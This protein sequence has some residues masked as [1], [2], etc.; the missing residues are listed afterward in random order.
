MNTFFKTLWIALVAVVA[1]GTTSCGD[2]EGI[3]KKEEEASFNVQLSAHTEFGSILT[4]QNNQAMYFFSSDMGTGSNCTG[5]CADKWPPVLAEVSDLNLSE[6]LNIDY[7]GTIVRD[8][9]SKQ[10]TYKGWPLYYFSPEGND[11]LETEGEVTGDAAGNSFFV[12]KPDYTVMIG[13][14]VLEDEEE[15]QTYLVNSWG[16]TIYDFTNDTEGVSNCT[17]G[18]VSAWPIVSDTETLVLPSV[19]DETKFSTV[20]RTDD[21]GDQLGYGGLPVY[22]FATDD[23]VRGSVKGHG[24][25]G[26]WFVVDLTL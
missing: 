26:V 5:G 23:N 15:A 4:N 14:Q 2:D 8:D 22:Y 20:E 6:D 17:G 3:D 21:L 24:S 13:K 11:V 7:F 25:G 18:C 19:L 9:N 10:L 16:V 1:L 12:A